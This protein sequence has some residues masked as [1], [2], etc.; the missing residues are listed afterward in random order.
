[1]SLMA[2]VGSMSFSGLVGLSS[3]SASFSARRFNSRMTV[4]PETLF[5]VL[6]VASMPFMRSFSGSSVWIVLGGVLLLVW[7]FP[8]KSSAS[9]AFLLPTLSGLGGGLFSPPGLV[10][11]SR[12]KFPSDPLLGF[13]APAP[14]GPGGPLDLGLAVAA[15][16]Q[17]VV[18]LCALSSVA[19]A[20][21]AFVVVWL[22]SSSL[23]SLVLIFA[24]VVS[25]SFDS[26]VP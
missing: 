13:L 24:A 8:T 1:M 15:T 4:A 17:G 7:V 6:L 14:D 16:F 20:H 12:T 10:D 25:L 19:A 26:W 18:A 21:G 22:M 11:L 23:R 2:F 5:I 3:R 9:I